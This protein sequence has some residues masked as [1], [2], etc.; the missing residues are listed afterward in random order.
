MSPLKEVFFAGCNGFGTIYLFSGYAT[1]ADEFAPGTNAV[2]L[3]YTRNEFH[4]VELVVN[5]PY[6]RVVGFQ[7]PV[8]THK[9]QVS[10][11]TK[12]SSLQGFA[13]KTRVEACTRLSTAL[14]TPQT[15]V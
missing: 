4:G 6:Y 11:G 9:F 7:G 3:P 8:G 5:G 1:D 13:G 14:A 12:S 2:L 15:L 10:A